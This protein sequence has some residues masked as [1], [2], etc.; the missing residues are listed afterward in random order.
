MARGLLWYVGTPALS[1]SYACIVILLAQK[2]RWQRLLAPLAAV[3]R[4]A[5][6]NYLLQSVLF[7]TIFQHY[8]LAMAGRIGPGLDVA[9]TTLIYSLQLPVSVWWLRHFRFGPAEWLWRKL[10]YGK[11][12]P[13]HTTVPA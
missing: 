1:F 4:T 2:E 11:L 8:G 6:S 12:Q 5:L 3:G 7:S 13:V 9:L 10:T